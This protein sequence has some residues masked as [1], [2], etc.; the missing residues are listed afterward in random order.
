[1]ETEEDSVDVPHLG[2][3]VCCPRCKSQNVILG[4]DKEGYYWIQKCNNCGYE[5]KEGGKVGCLDNK[6]E[7]THVR[8]E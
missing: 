1:M 4:E 6:N 7:P 8:E 3:V 5:G 2:V